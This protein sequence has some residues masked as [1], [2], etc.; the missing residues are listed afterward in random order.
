MFKLQLY[1]L[2]LLV[3]FTSFLTARYLHLY[4]GHKD[5]CHVLNTQFVEDFTA[6]DQSDCLDIFAKSLT[7]NSWEIQMNSWLGQWGWS[8]LMVY[9]P[10]QTDEIWESK[11]VS[12][13]VKL[14][15]IEGN[16]VVLR[17]HPNSVFKRGDMF[18][19][20]NGEESINS[21]MI[22]SDGGVYTIERAGEVLS[23]QVEPKEFKWDDKVE[24]DSPYFRVTSFRGEF[25]L[26]EDMDYF[27]KELKNLKVQTLY[28]DLRENYGGN[29]GAGLKFLSFF[30]CKNQVIGGFHVPKNEG[31]GETFYPQTVE[32][33][34]QIEVVKNH[35]FIRLEV[36]KSKHCYDGKVEVLVDSETSSTAEM[37]A[38]AFREIKNTPI[39]GILTSG[40][41]VL[42]SW[43]AVKNYPEGFYYSFPYAIY[44]TAKGAMIESSGV[45]PDIE[46]EYDLLLEKSGKDS[47]IQ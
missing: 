29:I 45:F 32:Q 44:T 25:F 20:V 46:R 17:A 21:S 28:I 3:A 5:M 14:R 26:E 11:S 34:V 13:G 37:V 10:S 8:H 33:S 7:F 15:Y 43:E 39:R 47:F 30:L 19:T 22:L 35:E 16:Y 2:Y 42:S 23:L 41:M 4:Q 40:R 36:P 18:L 12:V 24:I 27:S 31:K 38:M 1:I 6:K 9:A